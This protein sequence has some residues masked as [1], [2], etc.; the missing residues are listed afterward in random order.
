[1]N[2]TGENGKKK[3]K[4]LGLILA[5]IWSQKNFFVGFTSSTCYA[6]LQAITV[7]KLKES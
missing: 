6:L 2:Q 5:Q 4:I 3:K 1:M 7:S